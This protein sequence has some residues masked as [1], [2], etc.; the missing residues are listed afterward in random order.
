MIGLPRT[1]PAW[2]LL[3]RLGLDPDRSLSNASPDGREVCRDRVRQFAYIAD[4]FAADDDQVAIVARHVDE[5]GRGEVSIV[6]IDQ[7]GIVTRHARSDRSLREV[8]G[9]QPGTRS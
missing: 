8:I 5:Q 6:V 2:W 3:R 7:D 1:Q 9:A 4:R